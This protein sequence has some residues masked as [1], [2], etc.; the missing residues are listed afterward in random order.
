MNHASASD[1]ARTYGLTARHWIRLADLEASAWGERPRIA[2]REAVKQTID[3]AVI[4]KAQQRGYDLGYKEGRAIGMKEGSHAQLR[5]VVEA[6]GNAAMVN[7]DIDAMTAFK[8][9]KIQFDEIPQSALV[10]LARPPA[11]I[12]N[13]TTVGTQSSARPNSQAGT[14]EHL[15]SAATKMLAVLDT[16]PPIRRSWTQVA[17]LAGLKA[18]GGHFNTGKRAL[19]DTGLVRE[20]NGLVSIIA[21]SQSATASVADPM[22]LVEMW[23]RSLAGAAPK[24]LRALFDR[25]PMTRSELAEALGMKPLGGHWNS[26]LKELRD[27]D[28]VRVVGE[29][30]ELTELFTS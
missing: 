13:G 29:R 26:S 17:T 11:P 15:N 14:P 4:E 21:P 18:R 5:R 30:I 9:P 19:L 10:R 20:E 27:N 8:L 3:P 22:A 6:I 1:V 25:G 24:M 28:I 16:N 12:G 7:G 2:F 23:A